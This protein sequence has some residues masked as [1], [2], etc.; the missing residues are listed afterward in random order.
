LLLEAEAHQ[1]L[2][3][4]ESDE[5]EPTQQTLLYR[6]LAEGK[7]F[8]PRGRSPASPRCL[9]L[10][11]F[12]LIMASNHESRLARPLVERF[13]M[14]CRFEFYAEHEIWEVLGDRAAG[15]G[16]RTENEVV[17]LISTRSRG[18]PRIGL[19]LL[20]SVHRVARSEQA[21]VVTVAHFDKMYRI[22]GL[23][24][25][26]LD[27]TER[28]YLGILLAGRGPV[29]LNVIADRLGLP[30]RTVSGVVESFLV[31]LGLVSRT[32]DGRELTA[33]GLRYAEELQA[34]SQSN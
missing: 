4:D 33:E 20:E 17:S 19:R 7:L 9:P 23:D 22:E 5:M 13:K 10:E 32:D 15:L 27:R 34:Q 2:F 26:G 18:V 16:W 3:I 29:R 11:D 21:E 28:A 6:A 12:T 14:L 30:A 8:L 24:A 1:V 31:R 25:R